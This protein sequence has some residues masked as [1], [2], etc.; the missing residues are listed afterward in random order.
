MLVSEL[1][2]ALLE[3]FPAEQAEV[4]DRVG[5]S[6]GCGGEEVHGVACALDATRETIEAAHARDAN[7]LLTHHLLFLEPPAR[8]VCDAQD[9][10][11]AAALWRAIELGVSVISLH[12]N[13]DRSRQVRELLPN[14]LGIP[15]APGSLTSLE[16]AGAPD[17]PGLGSLFDVDSTALAAIADL[18]H[19][20]FGSP[21]RVWGP[22]QVRVSRIAMLGGSLGDFGE[23][24]LRAGADLIICGEAGYHKVLALAERG[25]H[26]MLLGHGVSEEPFCSILH[27]AAR[28]A[29]VPAERCCHIE[30]PRTWWSPCEGGF[31]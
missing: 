18:V 21:P 3:L 22:A 30:R 12:T 9:E 31:A 20:A 25:C 23:H 2:A 10:P 5:L 16:H 1:E 19:A 17:A 26:V 24:A 13:L 4:W 8:L 11:V 28:I 27:E 15:I 14:L 29:G 6:V 7:V